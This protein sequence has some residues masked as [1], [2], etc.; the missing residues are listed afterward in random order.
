MAETKIEKNQ[1]IIL[2]K[3]EKERLRLEKIVIDEFLEFVTD[4]HDKE[5]FTAMF[6]MEGNMIHTLSS[7]INIPPYYL[8]NHGAT[9]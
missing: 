8:Q 1:R 4:K 2:H 7:L 6:D 9:A 3:R 5:I